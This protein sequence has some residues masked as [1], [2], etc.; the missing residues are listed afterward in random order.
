MKKKYITGIDLG[1]T[2]IAAAVMN[3]KGRIISKTR[4][5]TDMSH[6][7]ES[8][9]EQMK[10]TVRKILKDQGIRIT[11]LAGIGIGAAGPLNRKTGILVEPPNLKG[12]RDIPLVKPLVD[13]FSIPVFLE[14][15]ANAAALAENMFGAGRSAQNMVYL[16]ISTG[17][18][19]GIII[20][21]KLYHGCS[22]GAGEIGHMT[23]DPDGPLC[24]CGNNGCFEAMASGTAI[25]RFAREKVKA[26]GKEELIVKKANGD[27]E[28]I[29]AEIVFECARTGD[30]TAREIIKMTSEHLGTGIASVINIFNPEKIV[31]GGGVINAWDMIAE[32][33]RKTAEKRAMKSL[34]RNVEIVPAALGDDVVLIGAASVVMQNHLAR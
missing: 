26:A 22:D 23:I 7:S 16:T 24:G 32:T 9:A 6:G 1:G 2:K 13:E 28:K 20:E 5:F 12:Y 11:E 21:G 8:L 25:A 3:F 10:R 14:N 33:V 29:T 18:G 19:G 27:Y 34:Y 31:L 30:S 15:D 4:E 17:I